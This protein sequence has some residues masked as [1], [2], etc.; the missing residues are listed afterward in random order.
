MDFVQLSRL[1]ER[2]LYAILQRTA[3]YSNAR[4]PDRNYGHFVFFNSQSTFYFGTMLT[5]CQITRNGF[6]TFWTL[7]GRV[8]HVFTFLLQEETTS[9]TFETFIVVWH[10]LDSNKHTPEINKAHNIW[11]KFTSYYKSA[12]KN[13]YHYIVFYTH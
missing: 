3:C 4:Q 9:C 8:D 12:S 7:D 11:Y 6:S 5:R 10:T 2:T 1:E 13:M